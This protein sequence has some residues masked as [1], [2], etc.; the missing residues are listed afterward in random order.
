MQPNKIK[1]YLV[2]VVALLLIGCSNAPSK[3]YD[4]F[5]S[6]LGSSG[7]TFYGAFWCPH[8][9]NQKALFGSSAEL[10]PYVE[11]SS[12]D[13]KSQLQTCK[14]KE[15]KSYPTWVFADGTRITGGIPLETLSQKT[16]CVLP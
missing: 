16:G 7:A 10:L 13:R 2:S 1:F 11:C 14:D 6:C 15:I 12:P 3:N 8:C 9:Q 5:A 4:T